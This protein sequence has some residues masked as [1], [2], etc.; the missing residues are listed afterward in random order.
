MVDDY[1]STPLFP[2][3]FC[4]ML[5]PIPAGEDLENS[6]SRGSRCQPCI[7]GIA[8]RGVWRR[9]CLPSYADIDEPHVVHVLKGLWVDMLRQGHTPTLPRVATP[10]PPRKVKVHY[11][12]ACVYIV[13]LLARQNTFKIGHTAT[14]RTRIYGLRNVYGPIK[15]I[16]LIPCEDPRPLEKQLHHYFIDMRIYDEGSASELFCMNTQQEKRKLERFLLRHAIH[17]FEEIRWEAMPQ[18]KRQEVDE[19]QEA[20]FGV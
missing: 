1:C 13:Q 11:P 18:K 4:G 7:H 3:E 16:L 17:R 12:S 10:K 9:A 2:C 19:A 15:P 20:L 5:C 14:M 8:E 6:L